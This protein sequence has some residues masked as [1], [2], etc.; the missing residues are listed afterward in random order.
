MKPITAHLMWRLEQGDADAC[1]KLFDSIGPSLTYFL[2]RLWRILKSWRTSIKKCSWQ[3]SKRATPTNLDVRSSL[4]YSQSPAISR[5]INLPDVGRE[6]IGK[7]WSRT[8]PSTQPTHQT[9]PLPELSSVLAELSPD[10]R[11]AFSMLK[12]DG[13][14]VEVAAARAGVSVGA[15][16]VG[17]HR[18]Y[19]SLKRLITG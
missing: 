11:E 3:F 1:Q 16:K 18:A 9:Q 19:K 6:L 4:G 14:S 8:R 17:A 13:L 15:L 5:L 10:H 2:R 12:L 7:N